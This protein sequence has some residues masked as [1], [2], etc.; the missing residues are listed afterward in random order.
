MAKV[1]PI[2]VTSFVILDDRDDMAKHGP[3]LIRIDPGVGLGLPEA[4]RA[5]E[6]LATPWP[7]EVRP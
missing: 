4:Q 7:R 6:M 1:G 3:R 2:Q 5:V